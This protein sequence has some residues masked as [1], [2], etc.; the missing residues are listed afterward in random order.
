MKYCFYI[1]LLIAFAFTSCHKDKDEPDSDDPRISEFRT[2]L[3]Y[4]GMDDGGFLAGQIAKPTVKLLQKNWNTQFDGN[5]ILYVD[6]G[7]E[8]HLL[9][10][11]AKS[12]ENIVDTV[13]VYGKENSA[14]PNVLERVMLEV[15]TA[16]PAKSYG[17]IVSTHGSGW[18]PVHTLSSPAAMPTSIIIDKGSGYNEMDIKDF[19]AVIPYKLDFLILDACLMG[20]IEVAYELKDKADYIVFSPAEVLAE[21]MITSQTLQNIMKVTPDLD[22]VAKAFFDFY[23]VQSGDWRSATV[24]VVKTSELEELA[25]TSKELLADLSAMQNLVDYIQ[26]YGYGRSN[27]LYFDFGDLIHKL[28]PG[29]YDEFM[30]VLNRSVIHKYATPGYYSNQTGYNTLIAY[31]GLSI[32]I[33]QSRYPY[34]NSEYEKTKW[35]QRTR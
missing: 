35:R 23:D 14:D 2:L 3:V 26:V 21:G 10:I 28:H 11:Y 27:K 29:R 18:L 20:G 16:W 12:G 32:Y 9:R 19:A 1:L 15:Q 30:Q 4:M 22:S 31:S 25:E 6:N 7:K 33:P 24:S 5:L 17:L 8:S 34:L 13:K